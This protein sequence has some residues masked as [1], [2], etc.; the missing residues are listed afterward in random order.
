MKIFHFLKTGLLVLFC[1]V[2]WYDSAMP[3]PS[4]PS[5]FAFVR[6]VQGIQE[7]LL[8]PNGLRVLLL[9][10]KSAPVVTVMVTYLVGSRH[11]TDEFRGGAH[12][13]E[14]MMFKGTPTYRKETANAIAAVLQRTGAILNASTWKDGTNYYESLPANKLEL[15]LKIEADRMRNSLIR[16]EDLSSEM[17]VVQSE[18]D[19][20]ENSALIALDLAVW[21]AAFQSHPYHHPIIGIRDDLTKM[22]ASSLKRFYDSYYWP[23]N[24]VLAII[25]DFETETTLKWVLDHFGNMP[26]SNHKILSP[27]IPEPEQN[28]TRVAQVEREDRVEAIMI[29]HKVPE[30]IHSDTVA[31]DVLATI[32]SSGK[33]S[34]L[35]RLLIDQALGVEV[36]S[37]NAKS[38]DPGLFTTEV[39]LT[40]SI[41]HEDVQALV[42]KTYDAITEKGVSERELTLAKNQ[43]RAQVAYSRDGSYSLANQLSRA[44]AAGDWAFFATY[45]DR[46]EE[47]SV[48]DVQR[49]AQ[50]YLRPEKATY[51]H[52]VSKDASLA[53]EKKPIAL[54]QFLETASKMSGD[55]IPAIAPLPP[56]AARSFVYSDS[57][58]S[59]VQTKTWQDI[60]LLAIPTGAKDVVSLAGSFEGAGQAYHSNFMVPTL[61]ASLLDEGTQN[62]NKYEIAS[63]L[64]SRGARLSF[65]IDHERV[66]FHA[67]CLKQDVPLVIELLAEQL[68][69]PLFDPHEFQKQIDQYKVHLRQ[70]MSDTA[71]QGYSALVRSIYE[72]DHPN[73]EP[74]YEDQI[75][76]LEAVTLQDIKQFHREFYGPRN[77]IITAAGDLDFHIIEKAVHT[78]FKNWEAKEVAFLTHPSSIRNEKP[79]RRLIHIPDKIKVDA[80][81]GH[82]LPLTQ[83]DPDY[84]PIFLANQILGGDF[85]ARLN[86]TVRDDQGLTYS[87]HSEIEGIDRGVEGHWQ[88]NVILNNE[89][90]E[91]GIKATEEQIRLF[92]EKGVTEEELAFKKET[93]TG[94]YQVSLST[95]SGFARRLLRNEELQL[96]LSYLD[97]F[98]ELIH[99]ITLQK[100][101]DSIR[102]YIHPENLELILCGT[103]NEKTS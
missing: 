15:A 13:L 25:G 5:E 34:R 53:A 40:P 66:G 87:I 84:L 73:Y 22:P 61:T 68:Q 16:A 8:K 78:H 47:V 9:E 28:E 29:S 2:F 103:L 81:F 100:T 76:M 4:T 102:R 93:V 72:P 65:Q 27:A 99:Q 64:E 50:T 39:I 71:A 33:T 82:A 20:L 42:L 37:E 14:H 3:Q 60:K 35:Y 18:F 91:R 89:V 62:K 98:P 19:R 55:D 26:A 80:Y 58:A 11:E 49:V 101:N 96:G 59:R 48:S 10:D 32:L 92:A 67:R 17:P 54:Q 1:M 43:L 30:A 12:L 75:K 38:Y 44:I 70:A 94:K 95:T 45:L 86:N 57:L 79:S 69:F 6:E 74:S 41:R 23:N 85:S 7:Y 97:R 88:I 63:L 36:Y 24:A 46:L 31:L 51:G 21:K 77:L 90:L 83:D 52:L 56:P